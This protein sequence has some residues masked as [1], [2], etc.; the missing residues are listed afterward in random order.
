[1][2]RSDHSSPT[3]RRFVACLAIGV[4]AASC[5]DS[6]D[7]SSTATTTA[8][9]TT[10]APATTGAPAS[11]AAAGTT[12]ESSNAASGDVCADRDALRTSMEALQDVD[13]VA[14]GTS[15][16]TAAV[17]AIQDDLAAL[18]DSAGAELQPD[19]QAVQ[20]ALD[21]L[22]TAVADLGSGGAAAAAVT[23][24]SNV[25]TSARTLLDS[26]DAGVCGGSTTTT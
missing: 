11:T 12:S 2:K 3:A 7:S 20:D 8:P 5:G 17:S 6:D 14:E 15:G 22:Q 16:V 21:Q 9:A 26:L 4:L 24:L 25:A 10:A 13:L 23:A 18:R 1:M 19:V